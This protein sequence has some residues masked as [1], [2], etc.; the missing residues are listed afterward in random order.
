MTVC[1]EIKVQ[2]VR[3]DNRSADPQDQSAPP[4]PKDPL[5][6]EKMVAQENLDNL[7]KRDPWEFKEFKDQEDLLV[8]VLLASALTKLHRVK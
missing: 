3:Q 1:L 7:E 8:T 5:D 4:V 6:S 2:Q